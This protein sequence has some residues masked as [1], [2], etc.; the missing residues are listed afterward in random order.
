M[1][2]GQVLLAKLK[3]AH[4]LAGDHQTHGRL[5]EAVYWIGATVGIFGASTKLRTEKKITAP[6][7]AKISAQFG[8]AMTLWEVIKDDTDSSLGSSRSVG[9]LSAA[10]IAAFEHFLAEQGL[11]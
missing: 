2:I 7:L 11:V 4:R 10:E 6:D 5:R 1:T 9:S 8:L 3:E